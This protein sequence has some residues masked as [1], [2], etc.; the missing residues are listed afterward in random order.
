LEFVQGVGEFPAQ[1]GDEFAVG[2]Q[3]G[4]LLAGDGR[5]GRWRRRGHYSPCSVFAS[6]LPY[7]LAKYRQSSSQ[8]QS[9][10]VKTFPS[11]SKHERY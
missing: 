6:P 1:G 5:R 4:R 3:W 9:S 8:H 2:G 10:L 7:E 11:L